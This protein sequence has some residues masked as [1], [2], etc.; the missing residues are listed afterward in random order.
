MDFNETY[1]IDVLRFFRESI[2]RR[3]DLDKIDAV[4]NDRTELEEE[5]SNVLQLVSLDNGQFI[6]NQVQQNIIKMVCD[7]ISGYG[8]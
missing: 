6:S 2:F 4:K 5:V 7:E 3:L 1:D 8:P